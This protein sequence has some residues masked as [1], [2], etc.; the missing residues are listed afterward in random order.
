MSNEIHHQAI[1][2]SLNPM[3]ERAESEGLWFY[4]DS[5]EVPELWA[6]VEYLQYMQSKG[7][8]VWSPE[9]WELRDPIEYLRKLHRDVVKKVNEYND[10]A[11]SMQFPDIEIRELIMDIPK[12]ED[13]L[14][15]EEKRAA[16]VSS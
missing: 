3:F 4:H 8:L 1:I 6:S 13:P 2:M 14:I 11:K 7:R 15:A 12:K 10:L 5:D 9:H 16:N